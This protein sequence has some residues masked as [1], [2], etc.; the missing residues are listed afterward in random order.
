MTYLAALIWIGVALLGGGC[1][2]T[3]TIARPVAAEMPSF[4]Q[5][6]QLAA[7][8]VALVLSGGAARGFAHIGVLRV[9]L[10]EG[11]RPDLVVGSSAGAI[12]GAVYASGM[13]LADIEALAASLGTATLLDISLWRMVK[14]GLG[15]GLAR[16]EQ[17]E[18]F[19]RNALPAPMQAFPIP[20]AAVATDVKT[21]E[22]V[23]LNHGDAALALRASS[24]VPGLYE[25]LNING[26]M[27]A[28]GQIVS[29]LPVDTALRLGAQRVVA[30]DVVYPPQQA[31]LTN[32]LDMVFQTVT[33]GTYRQMLLER[34]RAQVVISP[35]IAATDGQL[36]LRDRVMLI[37]A[38]ERA[39]EQVLPALRV[40]F[41]RSIGEG[42]REPRPD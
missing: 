29:P 23:V 18:G 38:G 12:V 27:L 13:P 24:A 5:P 25:P 40:L 8:R 10:R 7:P 41:G 28:D 14:E 21:G 17:L 26:R 4:V 34:S 11:L 15:L 1:A 22:T 33:I 39:A 36:G 30:V 3:A 16:G 42:Q 31:S 9:L 6:S 35:A 2:T 20:F 19:L 37:E 32:P